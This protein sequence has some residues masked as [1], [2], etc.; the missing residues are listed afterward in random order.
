MQKPDQWN[1]RT[2]KLGR[3]M[4]VLPQRRNLLVTDFVSATAL[5][6]IKMQVSRSARHSVISVQFGQKTDFC[7]S[8][9]LSVVLSPV[10]V[11]GFSVPALPL[12]ICELDRSVNLGCFPNTDIQ[13]SYEHSQS[14]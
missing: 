11:L 5:R 12:T 6:L 8:R 10:A 14:A 3:M 13:I 1:A 4:A 7:F 9:C 2:A